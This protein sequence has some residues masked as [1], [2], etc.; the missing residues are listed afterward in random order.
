MDQ[1]KELQNNK[2]EYREAK[3]WELILWTLS[4][5]VNNMFVI[6]MVFASYVAVGGYG[7]AV[8]TAG[9]ITSSTRIFDAI[10]D[11]ILALVSDRFESKYG[12]VRIILGLGFLVMTLSVLGVFFWGVGTNIIVYTV[13]YFIY[14]IGYTLFGIA[15]NMGNPIMTT[16][17]KQRMKQSGWRTAFTQIFASAVTVYMSMVLA[18]KHGGLTMGAFQ[19]LALACIVVGT[20]LVIVSMVAISSF[21]KM[22]NFP[23][24]QKSITLKDGWK[25]IK[26]NSAMWPYIIAAGAEKLTLQAASQSAV[27]TLIFGV[28]LGNYAFN[29]TINLIILIPT[30]LI[31]LSVSKL[32][33]KSDSKSLLI[34]WSW[35]SI[36]LGLLIVVFLFL[37]DPTKIGALNFNTILFIVIYTLY[38]GAKI[39][40]S[41][42]TGAMLPDI[43]DYEFYRSGRYMPATVAAI[44]SFVDKIISSF[45]A[46]LIAFCVAAIGYQTVMPQPTDE[47]SPAIFWMSMFMWM[48]LPII[49]WLATVVAMKFYPLNGEMMENVQ[50]ENEKARTQK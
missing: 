12:K 9:I 31:V 20:I 44:Y 21:D 43:V 33:G 46:T 48:G 7:I 28:I 34:K 26:D 37:T 40:T 15:Q 24:N 47:S 25:L 6:L 4:T 11:P 22:E 3:N 2:I 41:A 32:R 30:I 39:I 1:A 42:S 18:R 19:D 38:T 16:N 45:A 49:G 17:P 29:G 23:N 13:L 36:F 8:A 5:G 50:L 10:T 14:I 27:T 35:L